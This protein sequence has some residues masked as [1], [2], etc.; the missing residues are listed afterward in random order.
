MIHALY[1]GDTSMTEKPKILV[2]YATKTGS[3]AEVAQVIADEF[4]ILG[5]SVNVYNVKEAP[6]PNG[7][8]AVVI[9][10]SIR[11]GGWQKEA[12]HYLKTHKVP[13]AKIPV[14]YFNCGIFTASADTAKKAQ[15]QNYND[16][17][18][19]IIKPVADTFFAGKIDYG[20]LN[21]VER[22]LSKAIKIPEGD[23]RDFAAI[24]AWARRIYPALTT[25]VQ[26]H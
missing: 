4:V 17:A 2:L 25:G 23:K 18:K 11:Y 19:A 22:N 21:F 15:A 3:T 6:A 9:G 13:L 10:S 14:A 1:A 7:Y 20:K 26:L 16:A 24:R 8:S 12:L 5:S